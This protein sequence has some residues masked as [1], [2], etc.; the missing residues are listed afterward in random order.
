MQVSLDVSMFDGSVFRRPGRSLAD[1]DETVWDEAAPAYGSWEPQTDV[2]T[3]WAFLVRE[4]VQV[5]TDDAW[6]FDDAFQYE[7]HWGPVLLF[8]CGVPASR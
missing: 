8:A 3:A 6:Q 7:T 1:E 4:T 5:R 2:Q